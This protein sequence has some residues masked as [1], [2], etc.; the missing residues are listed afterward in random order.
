M[1]SRGFG[2]G[3]EQSVCGNAGDNNGEIKVSVGP[4]VLSHS[5]PSL[6]VR[7]E[8]EDLEGSPAVGAF[9]AIDNVRVVPQLRWVTAC[10][11]TAYKGN[12]GNQPCTPCPHNSRTAR[13]SSFH[14]SSCI[15]EAHY[16]G[17][18]SAATDRCSPLP[19]SRAISGGANAPIV[20]VAWQPLGNGPPN[21]NEKLRLIGNVTSMSTGSLRWSASLCQSSSQCPLASSCDINSDGNM[22]LDGAATTPV[23]SELYVGPDQIVPLVI[24]ADSLRHVGSSSS[25]KFTL[26]A[27][28][29][30][31][32]SCAEV[33]VTMNLPPS[34]GWLESMPSNGTAVETIYNLS[35]V[36]WTD[37]DLPLTYRMFTMDKGGNQAVLASTS[38]SNHVSTILSAGTTLGGYKVTYGASIVDAFGGSAQAIRH[39]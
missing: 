2:P 39:Q 33:V 31:I 13:K 15:C 22:N 35:A 20:S 5:S 4:L 29:A 32:A 6:E 12:I 21:Y 3:E 1:W 16:T 9:F 36:G 7:V 34:G 14:V 37:A 38:I 28:A 17:T 10:E 18:I 23:A 24:P 19:R 25:F 27:L 26:T 11:R 30:G 8:A